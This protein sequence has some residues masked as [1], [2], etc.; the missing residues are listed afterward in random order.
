MS[1]I[2]PISSR[3]RYT[4]CF[5][6]CLDFFFVLKGELFLSAFV[7]LSLLIRTTQYPQ[8]FTTQQIRLLFAILLHVQSKYDF[9]SLSL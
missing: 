5:P 8:G 9:F 1:E 4:F 3:K 2:R 7:S 6:L